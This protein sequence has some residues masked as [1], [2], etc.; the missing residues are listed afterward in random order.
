MSSFRH[1][2][3]FRA[4]FPRSRDWVCPR[5]NRS[6]LE[7]LPDPPQPNDSSASGSVS[8]VKLPSEMET[9]PTPVEAETQVVSSESQPVPVESHASLFGP[10]SAPD[11]A[12]G[13]MQ[14]E[15]DDKLLHGA[16]SSPASSP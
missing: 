5:C 16:S 12:D 4:N 11:G 7:C 6:N 9:V 14:S 8:E 1:H 13:T 3:C 10:E 2:S 15:G